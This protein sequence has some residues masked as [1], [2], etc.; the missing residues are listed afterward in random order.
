MNNYIAQHAQEI[1]MVSIAMAIFMFGFGKG[2]EHRKYRELKERVERNKQ[3][4]AT[5]PNRHGSRDRDY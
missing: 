5:R 3:P 2:Y 1:A 4:I